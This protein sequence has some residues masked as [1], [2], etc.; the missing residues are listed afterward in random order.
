MSFLTFLRIQAFELATLTG[1][2]V[3]LLVASETGHVYTFATPKLQPLITK[4]EGKN[5]IQQCLNSTDVP[6]LP[7]QQPQANARMNYNE[8]GA[9]GNV[10][11]QSGA[12]FAESHGDGA[13]VP[14]EEE[15]KVRTHEKS[16]D[17]LTLPRRSRFLIL[18]E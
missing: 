1:T 13:Y 16:R 11:S 7:V 12:G 18:L 2:Q 15:K 9:G 14:P 3:L 8:S 5:L 17:F 4:P 6:S 10:G